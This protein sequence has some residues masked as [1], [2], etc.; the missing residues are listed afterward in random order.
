MSKYSFFLKNTLLLTIS[1]FSSKILVFLLV[2][3]YTSALTTT[4]Y[5]TY[6]LITTTISLLLPIVS[7]NICE[8]V[9][10]FAMK[11]EINNSDIVSVATQIII[12]S[13]IVT[14]II[15][16]IN[17]YF[18][19]WDRLADYSFLVFAFFVT[20]ILYQFV[21]QYA[22][23]IED[24]KGVAIAGIMSTLFTLLFNILFL[25]VYNLHLKGFY[26][27]YIVGQLI[28]LIYLSVK[29][30]VFRNVHLR[31]N[32]E[33]SISMIMF[34]APL[35]FN[36]LGWWINSVSDR[37]I[38]TW[39]CGISLNG[40]YSVS[41][42]I[43]SILNTV[44]NIFN[45]A[46]QISAIKEYEDEKVE[47]FYNNV[48][49]YINAITV[50]VSS[51]LIISSKLLAF[52]LFSKD[53]FVAWMYVPFLLVSGV[54]NT[55]SGVLGPILSASNNTK[56]LGKSAIYGSLANI[57]LN[58]ILIYLIG[59]QGAAIATMISSFIIFVSR[60]KA[61]KTVFLFKK[62]GKVY[63][64]WLIVTIQAGIMIYLPGIIKYIVQCIIIITLLV[65]F[66]DVIKNGLT[67]LLEMLKS[68]MGKA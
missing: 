66:E 53:F 17:Y 68:R 62:I 55:A 30:K 3:I 50:L 39:L 2:P 9:M 5:G 32:R 23:G 11:K 34:S 7:L 25:I 20:N 64:S 4:E 67:S 14:G 61:L 41:Y 47:A 58:I 29:T 43:P 51:L 37:Y 56:A 60:K 24:V 57:A 16:A 31:L 6:D 21:T 59:V 12:I 8:A 42:K 26:L 65:L 48:L 18:K 15:I 46:W 19:I 35:I 52:F 1:N 22:K 54:I 63:F 13:I 36:S 27:A 40:I 33:L 44:Q 10:R 45:Q 49:D 38:V 28:P